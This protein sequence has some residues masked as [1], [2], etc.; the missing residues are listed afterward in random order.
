MDWSL[1]KRYFLVAFLTL[2][3]AALA[4]SAQTGTTSLHG[5]VTDI[6]GSAVSGAKVTL[7]NPEQAVTREATTGAE[8]EYDFVAVPPG[9]YTLTIEANGFR[10]FERTRLQLLVNTPATSNVKLEIGTALQSVEVVAQA[11]TLNT[12]DASIGNAFGEN[13]VKSLPLEGRNVP[14]L[15]SLQA[16]VAYTGNRSDINRNTDTRSGAVNGARSDQSNITLDG[17]DV[18][19]QVK[20]YAFSSILPVTV[21]SVQEFRV[22]TTNSNADQGRSSGAQVSLVTKSGTNNFHGSAYE[23]HRNT[24]TSANDYFVKLAQVQN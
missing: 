20:G 23:Y 7:I 22:I 9:T 8:G 14:D 6:S 18:N 1:S 19:D 16:G 2:S 11:A 5:A 4:A 13:Q 21:D 10:K 17:V 12:A 15:L 24:Y 3:L